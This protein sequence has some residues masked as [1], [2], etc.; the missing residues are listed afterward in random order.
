MESFLGIRFNLCVQSVL[1]GHS[2]D[3]PDISKR[4]VYVSQKAEL[5]HKY[6][7]SLC[8]NS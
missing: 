7:P 1:T 2:E 3:L 5:L 8:Q 4:W 6:L